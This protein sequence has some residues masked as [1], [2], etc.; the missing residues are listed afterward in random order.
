MNPEMI[1]SGVIGKPQQP[2]MD[3]PSESKDVRDEWMKLGLNA[4][5][6]YV[7]GGPTEATQP[8][9]ATQLPEAS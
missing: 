3:E 2:I 4:H 6:I 1:T 5:V 7:F 8:P 9:Q